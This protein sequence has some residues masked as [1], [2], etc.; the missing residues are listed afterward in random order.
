MPV[1]HA[2]QELESLRAEGKIRAYGLASWDSFRTPPETLLV[3]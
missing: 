2:L 1:L 3:S